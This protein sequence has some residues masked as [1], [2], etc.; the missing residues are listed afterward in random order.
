MQW[1]RDSLFNGWCWV[2]QVSASQTRS[3]G[4]AALGQNTES[5]KRRPC[6]GFS[7]SMKESSFLAN[8]FLFPSK[9][10]IKH[11]Q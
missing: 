5:A 6:T 4:Q 11:F 10:P 1:G 9:R 3:T 7:K 8:K 2:V